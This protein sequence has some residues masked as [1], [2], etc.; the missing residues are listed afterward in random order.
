[1]R[2]H[3][4]K[5]IA[6]VGLGLSIAL[7]PAAHAQEWDITET[8]APEVSVLDY[9]ASEGTRISLDVAPDGRTLVFDLLGHIYEMPASGGEAERLTDGRSWNM[10]PR[11]SPDGRKIAFTSDRSGSDDIWVLDRASGSLENI[12][13]MDLNVYRPNWSA[14]GRHIFGVARD[15]NDFKGLQFNLLGTHQELYTSSDGPVNNFVDD[16]ER[17]RIVFEHIDQSLYPFGFDPWQ[18]VNGG[19]RIKSYDKKTGVVASF[20]ERPGGAFN[21]TLSTDGRRLAYIHRDDQ[22]TVLV[23]HELEARR[24][25][26]LLRGLDRDRQETMFY[27]YGAFP[28]MAWSRDGTEIILGTG[29]RIHAVNVESGTDRIVP[30]QA[31]VHRELDRTIRFP[32]DIPRER[33]TTR[34]HRWGLRTDRG[35]VFEALGDLYLKS[36]ERLRN[37][38]NS[39]EHETSPVFDARTG[40]LYFAAWSDDEMGALYSR[41]LEARRP[42]RLTTFPSQYGSLSL[43]PDGRR[44]AFV[45][46]T[47]E[48]HNGVRLAQQTRFDLIVL[49]IG[50]EER[51]VTEISAHSLGYGNFSARQPPHLTFEPGGEGL[52]FTEFVNDTLTLKRIRIDGTDEMTLYRFPHAVAA[53]LSPDLRWIAFREYRRTYLT[54]YEFVGNAVTV[55]A[56]DKQG[57]TKRVDPSDGDY[58]RWSAD[59]SSLSWTRG[60]AFYEKTVG[61]ILNGEASAR[62]IDLSFSFDVYV[63]RSKIAL[64]GVRVITMNDRREVLENATVL[65]EGDEI[66]AVGSEVAVPGDARVFELPGHTV[67]PGIIDAHAHPDPDV[68]PLNVIEQRPANLQA[69]LAYGVTTVYEVYGLVEKDAWVSDMIR[70]GKIIGPRHFSTGPPIFGARRFRPRMYRSVKSLDDARDHAR[71]NKDHGATALKDYVNFTRVRRHQ[72]TTAARELGLN[73]FAESAANPEMNLT[74]II[75]GQTGIEHSM[76]L[77]PLYEDVVRMYAASEA[78]ITPTL[79]VVYNGPSGEANFHQNE[80]LWEDEKP[81]V[82]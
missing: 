18:R 57:F 14:D 43:A 46:G 68:S 34:L 71:F 81:G 25:R 58:L 28:G 30:F 22:E 69:E 1:M 20:I 41:R 67:I 19:A 36:G 52:F 77:T 12:S 49:A 35:I 61:E 65:I 27:S 60:A 50:G 53:S 47:G 8:R 45:R 59:G 5:S 73:V 29:G 40:T 24:E 74:Q 11:Y 48:L 51:R 80:R 38:T 42:A 17:D 10:Q 44:L 31:P 78:G 82:R 66:V 2:Q 63:P 64:T 70:A 54:P 6:A 75:D 62:R 56:E 13:K 16:P 37:F 76:G 15:E 23:V 21:P 39:T 32:I 55:S 9:T 3:G 33:A 7:A 72:I 79:L 4:P 26:V